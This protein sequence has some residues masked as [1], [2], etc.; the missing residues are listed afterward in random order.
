MTSGRAARTDSVE[1]DGLGAH[2]PDVVRTAAGGPDDVVPPLDE[3][4]DE[5]AAQYAGRPGDEDA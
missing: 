4:G 2:C 1:Y 5:A 3:L